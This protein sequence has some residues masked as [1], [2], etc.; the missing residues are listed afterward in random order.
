VNIAGIE[1]ALRE[2]VESPFD[3]ESFVFE[4]LRIY[5]APKATIPVSN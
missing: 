1:S 3:P 2:P 4:F 5:D